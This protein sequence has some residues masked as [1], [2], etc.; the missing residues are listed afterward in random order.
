MCHTIGCR[1]RLIVSM[2]LVALLASASWLR[3]IAFMVRD[4]KTRR[5]HAGTEDAVSSINRMLDYLVE[6]SATIKKQITK[7]SKP[8]RVARKTHSVGDLQRRW[9]HRLRHIG[10]RSA[11]ARSSGFKKDRSVG[12][13]GSNESRKRWHCQ[14]APDKSGRMHVRNAL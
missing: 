12:R 14:K 13:S 2:K 1:S 3:S 5:A 9:P 7:R 10:R 11:G 8:Y 6:E 4:E